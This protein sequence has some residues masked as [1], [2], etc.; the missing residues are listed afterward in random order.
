MR[1]RALGGEDGQRLLP[2]G[3]RGLLAVRPGGLEAARVRD[4]PEHADA[5]A[6]EPRLGL[7]QAGQQLER[8]RA[9]LHRPRHRAGVVEAGSE[10]EAAVDGHEPVA[11]L[12]ARR[13]AG[14]RR[15]ADRA[16]RV[17]ADAQRSEAGRERSGAPARGT[18]G[19]ATGPA[20]VA[21]GA[22]ER[23]LARHAPGELVQV[24]LADDHGAGVDEPLD[25]GRRPRRDV[26]TEQ[27]RAVRRAH[28]RGVEE[29]LGRERDAR[30][31]PEPA[32]ASER[33]GVEQ[34]ALAVAR[35]ERVEVGARLDAVEVVGDDLLGGDVAGAH[36][37]R[38]LVAAPFVHGRRFYQNP[39]T[40]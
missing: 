1:V 3:Q 29:V 38:D 2:G 28:P 18:A 33:A 24:G 35:D 15:D 36:A 16:T 39:A 11:R 34:R 13:T 6:R 8:E 5:Q 32:R 31:R 37:A 10:R 40:G 17:R 14:E 23:V 20:R 19:D 30:E 25:G 26:L 4:R 21:D 7:R 9:L 22:V 27:R 12:E